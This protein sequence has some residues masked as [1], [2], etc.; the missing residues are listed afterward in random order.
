MARRGGL[1]DSDL[2][3]RFRTQGFCVFGLTTSPEFGLS[4]ASEH[5]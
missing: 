5:R 2:A 1:V 4:L 3:E